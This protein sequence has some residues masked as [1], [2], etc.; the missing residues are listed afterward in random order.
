MGDPREDGWW[1]THRR[2]ANGGGGGESG[3]RLDGDLAAGG[4]GLDLGS[5]G[6]A[7][8]SV[9]RKRFVPRGSQRGA[10][11]KSQPGDRPHLT[12]LG[13]GAGGDHARRARGRRAGAKLAGRRAGGGGQGDGSDE[14]GDHLRGL[15]GELCGLGGRTRQEIRTSRRIAVQRKLRLWASRNQNLRRGQQ[16][17][18][19]A[20]RARGTRS[21]ASKHDRS[22][23]PVTFARGKRGDSR[24]RARSERPHAH[25]RRDATG[26][27]RATTVRGVDRAMQTPDWGALEAVDG[28]RLSW[29]ATPA[30]RPRAFSISRAVDRLRFPRTRARARR[31][32]PPACRCARKIFH[33]D[34]RAPR[35][36][37]ARPP[38]QE[39]LAQ[40]QDRG[41]EMRRPVRRGG[42]PS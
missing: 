23:R 7:R 4:G 1:D 19:R 15:R 32:D 20:A 5:D 11:K 18:V 30:S 41:D 13:G 27:P 33:P 28:V 16:R 29:C 31:P 21:R 10:V 26:E 42:D 35:R 3:E 24:S 39:R 34:A 2:G 25:E 38:S 22:A 12:L 17:P 8:G 6:G 14:G 37:P 9:S 36:N 40:Q